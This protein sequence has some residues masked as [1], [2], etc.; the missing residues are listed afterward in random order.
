[1]SPDQPSSKPSWFA[2][3]RARF[4]LLFICLLVVGAGNSMLLALA[5]PLVRGMH[6]PDQS[7]GWIFSVSAALFTLMSPFWG[8]LSNRLGRKPVIAL[9]LTGFSFS[10]AA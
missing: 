7:I 6:L 1:M 10:M 8:R 9:G 5:A 4:H 2:S 3:V